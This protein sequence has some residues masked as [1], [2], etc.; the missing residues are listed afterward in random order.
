MSGGD[1][2]TL[3]LRPGG[4]ERT[5][6]RKDQPADLDGPSRAPTHLDVELPL[7]VRQL[8]DHD[9]VRGREVVQGCAAGHGEK[10][11]A[12]A[13]CALVV[14]WWLGG[15]MIFLVGSGSVR[16][17]VVVFRMRRVLQECSARA[18]PLGMHTTTCFDQNHVPRQVSGRR[19][20][21]TVL[22]EGR[23][24]HAA[25]S[26]TAPRATLIPTTTP[27]GQ[28]RQ[29]HSMRRPAA[30]PDSLTEAALPGLR[31]RPGRSQ[32]TQSGTGSTSR[33]MNANSSSHEHIGFAN[34]ACC[35]A[36]ISTPGSGCRTRVRDHATAPRRR[37]RLTPTR[38]IPP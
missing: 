28:P 9:A 32:R 3:G 11:R 8:A 12:L 29:W 20:A 27:D 13:G 31:G 17:Q 22:L 6:V 37:P 10:M 21:T 26:P 5:K 33:S 2:I 14:G 35:W 24:T 19:K 1:T 18:Q 4:Q 38:S 25:A 7:L 30:L 36:A 23:S 16:D 15:C 34:F